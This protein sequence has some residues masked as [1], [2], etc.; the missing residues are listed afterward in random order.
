MDCTDPHPDVTKLTHSL[1]ELQIVRDLNKEDLNPRFNLSA[2]SRANSVK[3]RKLCLP[4]DFERSSNRRNTGGG[5]V[6]P[7]QRVTITSVSSA[8]TREIDRPAAVCG[9]KISRVV[10]SGE[11]KKME[12]GDIVKM[13]SGSAQMQ[14]AGIFQS[15][16][17]S[18]EHVSNRVTR[19]PVGHNVRDDPS[20]RDSVSSSESVGINPEYNSMEPD[21][22]AFSVDS[23]QVKLDGQG[24]DWEENMTTTACDKIVGF[25]VSTDTTQTTVNL[26]HLLGRKNRSV[27][28]TETEYRDHKLW[29][30]GEEQEEESEEEM[31]EEIYLSDGASCGD[32]ETITLTTQPVP[33]LFVVDENDT[34]VEKIK[35][36][37]RKQSR[38]SVSDSHIPPGPETLSLH[39]LTLHDAKS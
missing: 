33:Q 7:Q 21:M 15:D 31:E 37:R 36:G 39:T 3:S 9:A 26:L 1:E 4:A 22:D 25:E 27:E 12:D 6:K 32:P 38:S 8:A 5:Q 35:T 23:E 30:I 18:H 20:L 28:Q 24:G 10:T 14:Y 13:K 34:V 17:Q 16:Y 2:K 29:V 11:Q 19:A